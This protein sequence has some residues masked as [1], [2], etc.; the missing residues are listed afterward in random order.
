MSKHK[1]I[2]ILVLIII[3]IILIIINLL[4][5]KNNNSVVVKDN[6]SYQTATK[7]YKKIDIGDDREYISKLYGYTYGKDNVRVDVKIAYL[8]ENKVYDLNGNFISEYSQDKENEIL[9]KATLREYN[10]YKKGNDY[11]LKGFVDK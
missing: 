10:Y 4:I 6:I 2:I 5:R 9:E 1:K 8:E 3:I 7:L 11:S